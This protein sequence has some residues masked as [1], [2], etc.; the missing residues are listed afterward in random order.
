M[1]FYVEIVLNKSDLDNNFIIE[2]NIFFFVKRVRQ[3]YWD[4]IAT[5][6]AT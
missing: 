6:K 1:K 3:G 2:E 5:N 4:N